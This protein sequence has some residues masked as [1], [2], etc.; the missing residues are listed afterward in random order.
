MKVFDVCNFH[1]ICNSTMNY[2]E[3]AYPTNPDVICKKNMAYNVLS[4]KNVFNPK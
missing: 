1:Q 2:S 3:T 4:L